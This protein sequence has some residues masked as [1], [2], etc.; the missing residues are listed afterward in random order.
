[1][2]GIRLLSFLLSS[3]LSYLLYSLLSFCIS[4]FAAL[5]LVFF[6]SCWLSCLLALLFVVSLIFARFGVEV[7]IVVV[8]LV[9]YM[10]SSIFTLFLHTF[11]P[12]SA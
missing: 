2:G 7:L 11:V 1:M 5:L 3:F 4:S 9:R 12:F 8:Q 6:P 10:S